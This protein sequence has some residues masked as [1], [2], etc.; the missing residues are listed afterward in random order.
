MDPGAQAGCP[1]SQWC[2]GSP[3]SFR[4]EAR[5]PWTWQAPWW[6]R[7]TRQRGIPPF[8]QGTA[9]TLSLTAEVGTLLLP[10]L[11]Q[12][13]LA[14]LATEISQ[15]AGAPQSAPMLGMQLGVL[16][17]RLLF[18]GGWAAAGRHAGA[19]PLWT[20]RSHP[21]DESTVRRLV[22]TLSNQGATALVADRL[23]A[24]VEH[25]VGA[26]GQPAIA[27]SDV[28]DQEFY[29]KK[30]AHAGPIGR[31]GKRILGASYW[32]LTF[33]QPVD[34]P[35]LAY[36]VSGH[37]PASPLLDALV[38]LYADAERSAWLRN[39]IRIHN[40]DRGGNGRKV[41]LWAA[42]HRI[43]YLTIGGK[44]TRW[45]QYSNASLFTAEMMPVHIRSVPDDPSA[46]HAEEFP[47]VRVIFPA[48]PEKGEACTKA[49]VYLT[50]ASLTEAELM[51]MDVVYK[52]RWPM[53]E[54]QIKA[55]LAMGFGI[56]RDRR[57]EL[58]TSR[59]D[60]GKLAGLAS[61]E[62]ELR[63]EID[64]MPARTAGEK[65]KVQ[66]RRRRLRK[67]R[68]QQKTLKNKPL[69]KHA[70]VLTAG[71]TL[72]K[73]LMLLVL[74]TLALAL[75]QSS[76]TQLRTMSPAL[77]RDLLLARP[78]IACV[79]NEHVT[80]WVEPVS[81][82]SQRRLQADLL[83]LFDDKRLRIGGR[84]LRLRLRNRSTIQQTQ[85]LTA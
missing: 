10:A 69:V 38:D 37:K 19:E 21:Y 40:W 54:N 44:T 65:R 70:R 16:A 39:H 32:G 23:R 14:G 9:G 77:V 36:H 22:R 7:S 49:L 13:E 30:P 45:N 11:M 55:A 42:E 83:Q 84:T 72:C 56:N 79:E 3:G 51:T 76:F 29:T 80:L 82:A 8:A 33:V 58:T 31:L 2:I 62:V 50:A 67:V 46:E 12:P 75:H 60:D 24:Q 17:S 1:A 18:K 34:G 43:P 47:Q 64:G 74:N 25:V 57:Q 85:I 61:R 5:S 53:M 28:F 4:S 73:N 26:S 15:N 6:T 68:S 48:H 59:G 81:A 52:Q 27:F 41:L 71:E 63:R 66:T 20:G 78:A 35:S